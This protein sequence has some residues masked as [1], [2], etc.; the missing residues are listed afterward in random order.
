MIQEKFKSLWERIVRRI[1]DLL[2]GITPDGRIIIVLA[3]L[4]IFGSVAIYM[5]VSSINNMGRNENRHLKIEH[6]ESINLPKKTDSITN[7]KNNY[8]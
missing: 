4:F 6:I 8:E 1:R 5:T 2:D 7:N 3:M